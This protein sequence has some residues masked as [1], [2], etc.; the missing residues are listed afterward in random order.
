MKR[1]LLNYRSIDDIALEV[2]EKNLLAVLEPKPTKPLDSLEDALVHGIR[3]P[4]GCEPLAGLVHGCRKVLVLSDDN[5]RL[6]PADK[7]IPVL[8]D[9]LNHAGI[10]DA[11]IEIMIAQGTHRPMTE[12]EIVKKFGAEV[13][14][15]VPVLPH[16]FDN[17]KALQHLG[18]TENGTEIWINRKVLEADFVI[19]LG[20]ILP[21]QY[22]G[23]SG[24]AKIIQPGV[25]GTLT[26]GQTHWLSVING[27]YLGNPENP[28]RRE[29]E[30]VADK[31]G[32]D[33]I[34]NTVTDLQGRTVTVVCGDHRQAFMKGAA[35]AGDI[36]SVDC[37]QRADIA[38]SDAYPHVPNFWQG[39]KG[40]YTSRMVVKHGGTI[41]LAAPCLEGF[42]DEPRFIEL[43]KLSRKEIVRLVDEGEEKDLFLATPAANVVKVREECDIIMVSSGLSR[44]DVRSVEFRSAPNVQEALD[45]AYLRQ[46][47]DA[48]V[49]V[50]RFGADL[51]PRSPAER[52]V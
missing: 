17:P 19:G 18:T 39:G 15:R 37:P 23:F 1:I 47:K 11:Q 9:E 5:T 36:Y 32:L 44:E 34:I 35:A 25:S 30:A 16:E 33:F 8:L 48:K 12:E 26:T 14:R 20:N 51:I 38:V 27:L 10:P 2:E 29:M 43:M 6:T 50:L 42:G 4:I 52:E 7:I 13:P 24:G 46:G 22:A 3:H 28:I 31:A 49:A 45:L 21:H 41:I 40:I